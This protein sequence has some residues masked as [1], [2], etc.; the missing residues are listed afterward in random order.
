MNF[1]L[2]EEVSASTFAT[3]L[4][5]MIALLFLLGSCSGYLLEVLFRRF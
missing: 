1:L 2:I 3:E 4:F 5:I